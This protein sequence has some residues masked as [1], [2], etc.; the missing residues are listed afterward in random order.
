MM[1]LI[2]GFHS[3]NAGPRHESTVY[4]S[5]NHGDGERSDTLD[6]DSDD[7]DDRR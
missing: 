7:D 3:T 1:K 5:L 2:G 4:P 6:D